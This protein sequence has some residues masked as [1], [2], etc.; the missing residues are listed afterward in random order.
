MKIKWVVVKQPPRP[1][2]LSA[3][4]VAAKKCG[5]VNTRQGTRRMS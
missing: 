3:V 5:T 4:L 1:L 2:F